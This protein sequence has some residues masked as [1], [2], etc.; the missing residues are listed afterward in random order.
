MSIEQKKLKEI[1]GLDKELKESSIPNKIKVVYTS[2]VLNTS[3]TTDKFTTY[4]NK[5]HVKKTDIMNLEQLCLIYVL[6]KWFSFR[7]IAILG[8]F[9]HSS[10]KTTLNPVSPL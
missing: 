4:I 3:D 8:A 6:I 1:K 5:K 2:D 10:A 9:D 7:D